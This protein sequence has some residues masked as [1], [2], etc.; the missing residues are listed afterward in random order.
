MLRPI[1]KI[2]FTKAD[3]GDEYVFPF[4]NSFNTKES[5]ENL[6][7][8]FKITMPMNV[9][10]DGKP[11]FNGTNPVFE[12]GD[13]VLVEAGYY[14]T[15][16][17]IFKGYIS[18]VGAKVPVEIECEDDMFLLK[19]TNVTYPTKRNIQYYSITKKGHI[20]KA[21][22]KPRIITEDI[23]LRDLLDHILPD[24]WK[25]GLHDDYYTN[26]ESNLGKF[27]VTNASV[28]KVLEELRSKY[29]IYSYFRDHTLY[30][31][32][33]SNAADTNTEEFFFEKLQNGIVD[34][35]DLEWQYAKD[36][37][38]KVV[39]KLMGANNTFEEVT[40]GD[41]DG[42]Q[43]S[44]FMYWSGVG[45]KPDLRAFATLK[46]EEA[47]YDG[48]RGSFV[49]MGEPYVRHGDIA[50]LKSK[51]FPERD[52]DYLIVSVERIFSVDQGYKQVI[53]IGNRVSA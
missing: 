34:A 42:A 5:Y 12:R 21:L 47:K 49:T 27:V 20:G 48:Y 15:L 30:V 16:R 28:T 18:K 9:N 35:D 43:R 25:F 37:S 40:V 52:G 41:T 10:L 6:T 17:T 23:T 38:L 44:F 36:I 8:T 19:N 4:I 7:D 1:C 45:T 14:P 26:I 29:G 31:G 22:K 13:Y 24:N 32:L 2:T 53:E 3:S 39:A 50:R 33:P 51:K 46:L 11:I